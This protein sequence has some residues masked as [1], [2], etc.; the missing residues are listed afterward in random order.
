[1]TSEAGRTLS[2]GGYEMLRCA[3]NAAREHQHASVA[4]L[5]SQLNTDWPGRQPDIDEALSYWADRVQRFPPH[6][7][8]AKGSPSSGRKAFC[9]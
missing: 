4:A 2:E 3:V 9:E 6:D 7:F 8:P 1:M 5:R